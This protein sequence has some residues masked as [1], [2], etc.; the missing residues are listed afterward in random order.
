MNFNFSKCKHLS[1]GLNFP[2]RQYIMGSSTEL[3]QI[4]MINEENDLDITFSHDFKF[5]SHIHKIVQ[6]ANKILDIIKCTFK[7]FEPNIIRLLY[8]SL[9]RPQ[10]DYANNIWNPHLL[11]D[12]CTIEKI[13][14]R[15]TKLIPSFKQ[16]SY[17]ERLSI[18]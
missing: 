11:E 2:S 4:S 16:Y 7:Y 9:V 6:K 18:V 5:R 14:R 13:Q 15:A 3:H 12:T 8:T 17:H 10:L 1:F